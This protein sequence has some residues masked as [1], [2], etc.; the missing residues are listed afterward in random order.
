MTDKER[1]AALDLSDPF[2]QARLEWEKTPEKER[3]KFYKRNA[4]AIDRWQAETDA[5]SEEDD[6]SEDENKKG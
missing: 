3:K 5:M 4:T 2:V 1:L 6:E